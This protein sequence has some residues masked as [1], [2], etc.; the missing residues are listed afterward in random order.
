[1]IRA[2]RIAVL[3]LTLALASCG[4]S[5]TPSS[6]TTPPT[7]SPTPIA[8]T[9][10]R[11]LNALTDGG[12]ASVAITG[13]G[14]VPT[15]SDADGNFA[16]GVTSAGAPTVAFTG[17]GFVART[18]AV[19]VPGPAASVSLIPAAFD[20]RA[21]DEMFRV[22]QLLRWTAAPPL[23]IQTRTLQFVGV[24]D[25]DA[26]ALDEEMTDAEYTRLVEDLQWA[27]PQ[28]TGGRFT[29]FAGVTRERADVGARV[30]ILNSGTISIARVAGLTASTGFWGYS[31][32]SPQSDG[33]I[34]GGECMLDRDFERSGSPFLRSLRSHELG[35][36]L[37]YNHVT[38]RA[39]VMNS[40][41]RIEPNDFDRDASRIAFQRPPGNRAPD[42]DPGGISAN[43]RA[44]ISG[45]WAPAVP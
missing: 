33:T 19:R 44:P 1:V 11:V 9:S 15:T 27:L 38:V 25:S 21:F 23:R 32:W 37:G 18:T 36:A 10:G 40:A 16:V 3:P 13:N 28:L 8:S 4:G 39:S 22:S 5:S 42:V 35:H 45:V 24:N 7:L 43:N 2:S 30:H 14:V 12:A 6:P 26:T 41:A 17:S 29:G 31:R 20:L 34:T